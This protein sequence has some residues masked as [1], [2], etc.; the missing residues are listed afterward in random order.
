VQTVDTAVPLYGGVVNFVGNQN[1]GAAV[2]VQDLGLTSTLSPYADSIS[3]FETSGNFGTASVYYSDG[4]DM[5]DSGF[6]PL[7]PNSPD[8]V[9]AN[10]GIAANVSSDT[11]WLSPKP[12]IAQ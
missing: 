8:S 6:T 5:L 9:P 1:P 12:A 2:K 3:T 11:V 4:T 10:S 7:P